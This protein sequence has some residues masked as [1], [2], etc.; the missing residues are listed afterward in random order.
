[1]KRYPRALTLGE[2]TLELRLMTARDEQAIAA[3]AKAL[4]PHDLLYVQRDISNPKVVAA[5]VQA[6]E[7][8][9]G[10]TVVAVQGEEI[11]ACGALFR[12][13]LSWSP[14]VGE[15]RVLVAESMRHKGLGRVLIQECFLI[16]VELD[17]R[18]LL[19]QMTVDQQGAVAIFEDLGFRGEALLKD[20]VLDRF[21]DT[22]DIVILS[23]DV[24]RV[25]NQLAAYG[26]D[27]AL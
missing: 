1:M 10:T 12:D 17:L 22:H 6:A 8:G 15:V 25:H 7:D 11:V 26:I 18:K 24:D 5:W 13:R 23:C 4:P 19:A 20:Q 14:H 2:N 27:S 3:F 21:G 16:A 9:S